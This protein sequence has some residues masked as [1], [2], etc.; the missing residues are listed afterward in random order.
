MANMRAHHQLYPNALY[1]IGLAAPCQPYSVH[2]YLVY[3]VAGLCSTLSSAPAP[4]GKVNWQELCI[5]TTQQ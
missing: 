3:V 4:T 2:L 1:K 5:N